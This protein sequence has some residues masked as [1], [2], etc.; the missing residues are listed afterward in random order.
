MVAVLRPPSA[1]PDADVVMDLSAAPGYGE[2]ADLGARIRDLCKLT[3]RVHGKL[4]A[5]SK[6]P[7]K[8]QVHIDAVD[9]LAEDHTPYA[10]LRALRSIISAVSAS[11][12][13]RLILSLPRDS[14]FLPLIAPASL[15]SGLV[16]LTPHNP[17]AVEAMAQRLLLTPEDPRFFSLLDRFSGDTLAL[18][19]S[20]L[21]V[22][23]PSSYS[24]Q[25]LIRKATGGA[26]A[27][28][29]AVEGY[30]SGKSVPLEQVASFKLVTE[31]KRTTTH[32][33]LNLP[34]N[35][36]LTDRQKNER[37]AVPLPY[38]HEGEG[39]DLGMGMDWSDDEED[40]EI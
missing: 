23:E 28:V 38:A 27:I 6:L 34:F 13:G 30:S 17:R 18:A 14:R 25:V 7:S 5:G 10:V 3:K 33:D 15:S 16:L 2:S 36:S 11:K 29:R 40:D 35:L 4:T 39:A 21:E 1:Y 8:A 31:E 32:A 26:K 20:G 9:I 19:G 12:P 37:G 24:V 22:G